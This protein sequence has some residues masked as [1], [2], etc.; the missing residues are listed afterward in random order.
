MTITPVLH[1]RIKMWCRNCRIV[2]V[3]M[4]CCSVL[5]VSDE[6]Y[7]Q[8]WSVHIS[9]TSSEFLYACRRP[10]CDWAKDG[11]GW[12]RGLY[13]MIVMIQYAVLMNDKTSIKSTWMK[14]CHHCCIYWPIFQSYCKTCY[15]HCVLVLRFWSVDHSCI[16]I[17][18]FHIFPV[19]YWYLSDLWWAN[20]IFVGI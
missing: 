2:L 4:W 3:W 6:A 10:K 9:K 14:Y 11:C 8:T 5:S 13:H 16:L 18:C 1:T 15:F 12:W 19:F 20:W 17:L 7:H